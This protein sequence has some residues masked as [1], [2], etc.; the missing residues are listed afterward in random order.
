MALIL[1]RKAGESLVF[2]T[3]DGPITIKFSPKRTRTV[4]AIEAPSQVTV[5][6][7]EVVDRTPTPKGGES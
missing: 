6:R 7:D 1:S 2:H 5:L 3:S 4:V